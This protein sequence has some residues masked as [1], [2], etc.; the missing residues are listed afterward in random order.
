ME[1]KPSVAEQRPAAFVSQEQTPQAIPQPSSQPP[2][3]FTVVGGSGSGP[4]VPGGDPNGVTG[5]VIDGVPGAPA[6]GLAIGDPPPPPPTPKREEPPPIKP[7]P[8]ISTVLQGTA[9]RRVEPVYPRM[10]SNIGVSGAVV[11]EV[12]VDEAGNVIA[13]RALSGHPLLRPAA[14]NAARGWRWN[15]TLLNGVPVQVVGTITFNFVR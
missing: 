4:G 6:G 7:S 5:G 15:P 9:I 2:V 8:R 1:R 10:A 14:V 13:A 12:V 3:D 11:V